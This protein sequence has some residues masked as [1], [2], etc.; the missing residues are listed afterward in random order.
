M[1]LNIKQL[2]ARLKQVLYK[3]AYDVEADFYML[4]YRS[5]GIKNIPEINAFMIV[6]GW[7]GTAQRGGAW[8]FYEATDKEDI[9]KAV[10]YLKETCEE[11]MA[12]VIEKGIHDY[13]DPKYQGN[14]DYPEEWIEEADEIDAWINEHEEWI[15]QWIYNFLIDNEERIS[16]LCS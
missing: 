8:T 13:D 9:K 10:E 15:M 7:L 3:D 16:E 2:F 12:A 5:E 14:W 6:S 11:E 4:F 1:Y